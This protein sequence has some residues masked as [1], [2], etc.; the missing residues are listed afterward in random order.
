MKTL[1]Y[2]ACVFCF[3]ITICNCGPSKEEKARQ[4]KEEQA[5]IE[6]LANQKADSIAKAAEEER[7]KLEEEQ[8]AEEEELA[9]QEEARQKEEEARIWTGASSIEELKRKL[10][11]TTWTS[12]PNS[13][14]G[15]IIY[16]FVFSNGTLRRYYTLASKGR[17]PDDY[18]TFTY[19]VIQRRDTN[20]RPFA[21]VSFGDGSDLDHAKQSIAF[22]GEHCQS[23]VWFLE[24]NVAGSLNYGDYEWRDDL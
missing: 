2:S 19:E 17:W 22:I 3:T 9:R 21:D 15:G 1:F 13:R 20:G 14:Y 11:G 18:L 5:R 10:E 12:K 4:A 6:R 16:K 8:R 7:R 24:G 23:A